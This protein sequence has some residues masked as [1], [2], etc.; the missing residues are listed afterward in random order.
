MTIVLLSS[1]NSTNS[2]SNIYCLSVERSSL[3]L[4]SIW[5]NIYPHTSSDSVVTIGF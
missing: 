5:S 3:V 1:L 4:K 2:D